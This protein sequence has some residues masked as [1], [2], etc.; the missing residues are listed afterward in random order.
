M[1]VYF[2]KQYQAVPALMQLYLGTGGI[3][4]STRGSTVKAIRKVYPDVPVV[5]L[6]E[7]FGRF[8]AGERSLRKAD[9]IITGSPNRELLERYHARK[10]MVFHGT[11]AFMAQEEIDGLAHF[12]I[13]C[14]IGP[15]MQQALQGTGLE[16]KIIVSGYLPFMEFPPRDAAARAEYLKRL[17]LSP[18]NKTLLYLPRGRPYG[19]WDIMAERLLR[20][21]PNTYNLI[22]RPHPSQSVTARIR[23]HFR[24]MHL[25][26]L[27]RK[28][29]NALLDLTTCKLSTLL[30]V[31]DLVISDGASSPEEALFY[32]LPQ[33][34]IESAGS[35]PT[36]IAAMMRKKKLSEDYIEKLL[37]IYRCGKSITPEMPDML[38]VIEAAMAESEHYRPHREAYF[39][40]VFGDKEMVKQQQL[41]QQLRQY[42]T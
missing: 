11:Y 40:W 9:L 3:F 25:H 26:R 19:S 30:S 16:S 32:D 10:C 21:M 39:S 15:R 18:Q 8:S 14:A 20:Q 27:C 36:A 37:T 5:K 31:A 12:D 29:G 13:I 35:S 1:I 17:C 42:A 41:I 2:T 28:R 38:V 23:D 7:R 4:V 34:F 24:F 22:L 33:V 6:N